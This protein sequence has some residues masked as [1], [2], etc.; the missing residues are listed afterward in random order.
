[1]PLG[2]QAKE[3]L[4]DYL[5]LGRG[6]LLRG[7]PQLALFLSFRGTPL[8]PDDVTSRLR[9]LGRRVKLRVWPHL[10]RHTCATHLLR[11]RADIRHIQRLLGHKS[12]KTTERYTRV[13][14]GDLRRVIERCHP[15]EKQHTS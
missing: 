2:K 4:L 6:A 3:A 5:D 9:L 12:L 13:E 7:R 11:G 10:L 14:V 15:R 1:V 8:S